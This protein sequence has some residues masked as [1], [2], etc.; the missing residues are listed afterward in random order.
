MN[1]KEYKAV[2][3][4]VHPS[5]RAVERI[6]DMTQS[7][8]KR[9]CKPILIAAAVA[10]TLLVFGGIVAGAKADN[11]IVNSVINWIDSEKQ[12][13]AKVV[14]DETYT[15]PKGETVREVEVELSDGTKTGFKTASSGESFDGSSM[16]YAIC[17]TEN[18]YHAIGID[19]DGNVVAGEYTDDADITDEKL[20]ED[21]KR[22]MQE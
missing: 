18:G 13:T 22:I 6:I 7:R 10:L 9:I 2:F 17:A 21:L 15:N 11:S 3:S 12:A 14:K 8:K 5:E 1:K 16:V 19:E 4:Q 20:N